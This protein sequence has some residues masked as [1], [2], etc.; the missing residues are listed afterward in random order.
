M[1]K[2]FT[3]FLLSSLFGSAFAGG[4][5]MFGTNEINA[6]SIFVGH[7][8][9]MGPMSK[10]VNP[11][12]WKSV[13]MDLVMLGYSQP[14][15]IFRLPARMNLN[16]MQ[17]FAYGSEYDLDFMGVGITWDVALLSWRGFYIGGGIGPFCRDNIDRW[18]GSR[19]L[20]NERFFIGKNIGDSF[21]AELFTAH[22]SNG[23]FAAPNRGFN[24]AGLA[25]N[26]SF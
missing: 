12:A 24:F 23:D 7:G 3:T 20:F 18:V 25:L 4:N 8:T 1:K 11:T 21:R 26:Y 16:F 2:I 15:T 17:N 6:F 13:P 5:V 22:F 10:I 9:G 14:I 19:V